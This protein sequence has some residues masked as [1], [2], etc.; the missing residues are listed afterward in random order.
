MTRKV[1]VERRSPAT[2]PTPLHRLERLSEAPGVDLWIKRDDRC[3]STGAFC[4]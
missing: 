1:L 3:S 2:L 4:R